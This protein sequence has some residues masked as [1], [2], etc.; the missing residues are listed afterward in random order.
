MMK[1]KDT[2]IASIYKILVLYENIT[3]T[4][5]PIDVDA[6][7]GY[8]DRLYVYW[9]GI[10]NDEVA[11]LLHGLYILGVDAGHKRVKSIVFHIIDCVKKGGDE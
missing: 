7:L 2:A 9:V 5:N 3:D 6:Y 10:G 1:S 4:T 11:S 8:I